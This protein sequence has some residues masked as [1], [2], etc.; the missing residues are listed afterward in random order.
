MSLINQLLQDL[1]KRRASGPE[2][3]SLSPQVRA[4]PQ[5]GR[6]RTLPLVLLAAAILAAVAATFS[7]QRTR[8][9]SPPPSAPIAAGKPAPKP[10]PPSAPQRIAPAVETALALP[11]FRLARE[12]ESSP[13]EPTADRRAKAAVRP[14]AKPAARKPSTQTAPESVAQFSTGP[15]GGKTQAVAPTP[16]QADKAPVAETKPPAVE[17][18]A[19]ALA[20]YEKGEIAFRAGVAKLQQGRVKDAEE[21]FRAALHEDP[22]HAAARQALIGLLVDAGHY[23]DAEQVLREALQVN[24]RQPRHAMLLARLEL[25]RGDAAAAVETLQNARQ[26]AAADPEYSAFFAAALQRTGRHQEAVQA[27]RDALARS[28]GNAIWLIGLGISLRAISDASGARDAFRQAAESKSLSPELQAF[29]DS[30]LRELA[31]GKR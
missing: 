14:A 29:A 7:W 22:T 17:K 5:Q 23:L 6:R 8:E 19:R 31:R 11:V 18:Q 3:K 12:L 15:T 26:Y 24:P 20:P 27:Y 1:E 9:I 4:L 21:S 10:Q 25:E 13:S 30:Q 2:M 16:A 28:P